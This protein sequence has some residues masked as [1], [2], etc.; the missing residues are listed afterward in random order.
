MQ[1]LY[2]AVAYFQVLGSNKKNL[3]DNWFEKICCVQISNTNFN[4]NTKEDPGTDGQ[5]DRIFR[6]ANHQTKKLSKS[7]LTAVQKVILNQG[8][9]LLFGTATSGLKC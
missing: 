3:S 1:R 7:P 2:L 4:T 9:A 5:T 6:S 8:S